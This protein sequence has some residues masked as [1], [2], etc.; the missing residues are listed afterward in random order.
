MGGAAGG[1]PPLLGTC[2]TD[3]AVAVPQ[4]RAYG[5]FRG[6]NAL[7]SCGPFRFLVIS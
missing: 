3:A 5:G 2:E 6:D 1:V 7:Q 4:V